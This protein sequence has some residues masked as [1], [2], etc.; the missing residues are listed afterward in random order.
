L[1]R[2]QRWGEGSA[3]GPICVGLTVELGNDRAPYCGETGAGIIGQRLIPLLRSRGVS[4]RATSDCPHAYP[5]VCTG[6]SS[7]R[8][9]LLATARG[10]DTRDS[11]H[12]LSAELAD[13]PSS[14]GC[15][16]PFQPE[17]AL[18]E[19][20]SFLCGC[21]PFRSIRE[22]F[23]G[24]VW[25][26]VCKDVVAVIFATGLSRVCRRRGKFDL[27]NADQYPQTVA[28]TLAIQLRPK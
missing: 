9:K 16:A 15:R 3:V 20:N 18:P 17:T 26:Q 25:R 13:P 6:R 8:R 28:R 2:S 1:L 11:Q 27:A 10:I 24:K 7:S 22:G 4:A 19:V 12:T 21:Q 14:L 23:F 5:Q